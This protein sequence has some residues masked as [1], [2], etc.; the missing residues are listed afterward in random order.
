MIKGF[1]AIIELDNKFQLEKE[2]FEHL[3]KLSLS[4]KEQRIREDFSSDEVYIFQVY[5][6]FNDVLEFI[7][8]SSADDYMKNH[9]EQFNNTIIRIIESKNE[10]LKHLLVLIERN[11]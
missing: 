8:R 6:K 1:E 9:L 5:N 11:F 7:T 2:D 10:D 4:L 3:A